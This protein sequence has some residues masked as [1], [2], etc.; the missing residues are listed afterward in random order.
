MHFLFIPEGMTKRQL[1]QQFKLFYK[2]HFF[3]FKALWNYVA[4]LWKSP[5]SWIRFI[6]NIADFIKFAKN[7]RRRNDVSF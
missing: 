7:N 3:R 5:D 4:M 2:T 6:R 1:E